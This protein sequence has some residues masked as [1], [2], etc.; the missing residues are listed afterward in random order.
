MTDEDD[1]AKWVKRIQALS[2][3]EWKKPHAIHLVGP[4]PF[5]LPLSHKASILGRGS[6]PTFVLMLESAKESK[7]MRIPISSD[8]LPG[9]KVLVDVLCGQYVAATTRRPN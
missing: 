7:T 9:L 2:R 5:E 4:G 6:D 1:R 3:R 8:Q